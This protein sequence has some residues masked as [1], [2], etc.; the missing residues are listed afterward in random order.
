MTQWRENL[1][2]MVYPHSRQIPLGTFVST[3]RLCVQGVL[4]VVA[5][6]VELSSA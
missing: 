6:A 5:V 3:S 1:E 2:I 4:T